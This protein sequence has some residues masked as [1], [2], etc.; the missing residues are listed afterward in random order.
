[1]GDNTKFVG[2]NENPDLKG[3]RIRNMGFDYKK[4][5]QDVISY[6]DS[7]PTEL[8]R[9][10][11]VTS[12]AGDK[13]ATNS[14]HYKH[15]A[16]DLGYD[17]D[18]FNYIG[19]DV[20]RKNVILINPNHGTGKHLHISKRTGGTEDFQDVLFGKSPMFKIKENTQ[21]QTS[22]EEYTIDNTLSIPQTQFLEEVKRV[23]EQKMLAEKENT[24]KEDVV[25]QLKQK[26]QAAMSFLQD[27]D[28]KFDVQK[29][30]E[31][32]GTVY[33]DKKP[34]TTNFEDRIKSPIEK[35][36]NPDGTISTHK[37]MSFEA[38]GKFYAAPTIVKKDGKLVELTPNEAID[39]A[40]KNNEFKV[41]K[42]D[43]EAKDYA[44]N[45]YKKG[46]P[47]EVLNVPIGKI[48]VHGQDVPFYSE[49][50]RDRMLA[51]LGKYK[52]VRVGASNDYSISRFEEKTRGWQNGKLVDENGNI[53]NLN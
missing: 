29:K 10:V 31:G 52:P 12:V 17:E 46:T 44:N 20:N 32:G 27:F 49:E 6:L 45:G 26:A 22:I 24:Q 50:Q 36:M 18:L 25:A 15:Q 35:I 33:D 51:V 38:D 23:E 30:M 37:M 8:Q 53:I 43:Q 7:L 9:K 3:W 5:D 21:E 40:F 16:I 28:L 48:N 47:M 34:K 13:H 2:K 41:F 19:Q 39:F 4:L 11:R 42:T 14:R 1:M